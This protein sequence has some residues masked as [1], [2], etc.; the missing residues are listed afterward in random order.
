M[1]A[2]IDTP[3]AQEPQMNTP[4]VEGLIYTL[5]SKQHCYTLKD[6][7]ENLKFLHFCKTVEIVGGGGDKLSVLYCK[8]ENGSFSNVNRSVIGWPR[9]SV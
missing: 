1:P 3:I 4:S 5:A 8:A 7:M 9:N 2:L 6:V